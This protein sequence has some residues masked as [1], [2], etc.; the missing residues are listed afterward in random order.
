ML[1]FLCF[2]VLNRLPDHFLIQCLWSILGWDREMKPPISDDVEKKKEHSPSALSN[3]SRIQSLLFTKTFNQVKTRCE[4]A[5][6]NST[7]E[8]HGPLHHKLH[9]SAV[10]RL[11]WSL[12]WS[13]RSLYNRKHSHL[14]VWAACDEAASSRSSSSLSEQLN[15]PCLCSVAMPTSRGCYTHFD[16]TF[17]WM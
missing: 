6:M 2:L 14:L 17:F 13:T 7:A 1:D 4:E 16:K 15:H 3:Y 10:G 8:A 9:A 12:L 5:L 11:P